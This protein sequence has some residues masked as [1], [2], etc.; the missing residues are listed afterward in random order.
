MR[1]W[2]F[3][4]AGGWLALG[5]SMAAYAQPAADARPQT[6]PGPSASPEAGSPEARSPKA[7][8]PRAGSQEAGPAEPEAGPPIL[9]L[10]TSL[11]ESCAPEKLFRATVRNI[12][13]GLPASARAAQPRQMWRQGQIY[14]RSEEQPDPVR[15][16]QS[17]AI[18]AE[19]DIWRVNLATREARHTVD[20]GPE[21]VVRAPILPVGADMPATFR[22]LEFGCEPDFVARHAPQ[23]ERT[24]PWGAAQATLHTVTSG[25]HS[26]AF[27]MDLR[28]ERPLMVSYQRGGRPVMVLRYDDYRRGLP[29]RPDLFAPP[30]NFRIIPAGEGPPPR[31][32]PVD[33]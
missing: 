4:G 18:V 30:R 5:L 32:L 14:F 2:K 6:D 28:R 7:G 9:P 11:G 13:P 26:I 15:G 29:D 8:S 12:S 33:P 16:D 10:G 1:I 23:P 19:P 3:V 21:L 17:V 24:V 22:G 31:P 20:P 27:L 25:E